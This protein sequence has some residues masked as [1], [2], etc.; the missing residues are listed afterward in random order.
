MRHLFEKLRIYT[1]FKLSLP[2]VL[3]I[4]FDYITFTKLTD[5]QVAFQNRYADL[6]A[7]EQTVL[8]N[9]WWFVGIG[10]KNCSQ[11]GHFCFSAKLHVPVAAQKIEFHKK[12][13]CAR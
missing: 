2:F 5:L 4:D 1:H 6:N 12:P 9:F 13:F 8:I 11:W 3:E 10:A 7:G